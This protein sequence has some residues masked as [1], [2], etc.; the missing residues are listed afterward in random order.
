MPMD[1]KEAEAAAA[2]AAAKNGSGSSNGQNGGHNTSST[3]NNTTSAA[4]TTNALTQSC[5]EGGKVVILNVG[6]QRHE[7]LKKIFDEFPQSRLWRVMRTNTVDEILHNCDRYK[8]REW[9]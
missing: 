1:N 7:A 6:G 3:S 5:C 8:V 9:E 4:E 2:A